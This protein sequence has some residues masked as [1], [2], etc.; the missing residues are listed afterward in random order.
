MAL[1]AAPILVPMNVSDHDYLAREQRARKNIDQQLVAAGW[2][3]QNGKQPNVQA[4]LGVAVREFPLEKP[5]GRV[6]YL[7]FLN[8]QPA[9]VIEAKAEGTTLVEVESQSGKYVEGLPEW[10]KPPIYPL[11]FIYE[12]TGVE[13]RFTNTLDPEARSRQV[14]WF[15]RPETLAEWNA[16]ASSSSAV[17]RSNPG[18]IGSDRRVIGARYRAVTHPLEGPRWITCA[19]WTLAGR[20]S[21]LPNLHPPPDSPRA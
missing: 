21:N 6:D 15:H 3:V 7:L 13:T 4:G 10:M 1:Q 11:P 8:G 16:A 5:H 19:R 17:V 14:F 2:L 20:L 18:P 12:S 9:G